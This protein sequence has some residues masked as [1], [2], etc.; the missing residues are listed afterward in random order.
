MKYM[1]ISYRDRCGSFPS[2][3]HSHTHTLSLS[4]FV[5]CSSI[6][7]IDTSVGSFKSMEYTIQRYIV[8]M[9][10]KYIW[11]Y[12]LV[13]LLSVPR[14]Y[15]IPLKHPCMI[16]YSLSGSL[17]VSSVYACEMKYCT[18]QYCM[19]VD[20]E[21]NMIWYDARRSYLAHATDTVRY[22]TV[23]YC[24]CDSISAVVSYIK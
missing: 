14:H 12:V 17:E 22:R 23:L 7:I 10:W 4:L 15:Q 5:H 19:M 3:F 2:P 11:W 13:L 16:V 6:R 18:V 9:M 1:R 20:I 21:C 8:I 24:I